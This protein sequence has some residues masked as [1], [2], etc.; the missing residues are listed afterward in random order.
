MSATGRGPRS[1]GAADYYRTPA[2]CVRRVLEARPLRP[3]PVLEPC[4]GDGAIVGALIASG[5]DRA[6]IDAVELDAGLAETCRGT[7]VRVV[8]GDFGEVRRENEQW[9]SVASVVMNPP[10]R[11]AQEFLELVFDR[12]PRADVYALLRL[13]FLAG[14]A[15]AP[16]YDVAGLPDVYV[17]PDRP[18]FTGEGTDA[19]DYGWFVWP[20]ERAHLDADSPALREGRVF[21]LRTTTL[22]ERKGTVRA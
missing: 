2:W 18:V 9:D 8:H 16:F 21:Q 13:N 20:A 10:Y 6:L 12:C 15:R 17:L 11:S 7:G 1:G 5:V 14:A 19:C 22:N 3:G 4:A